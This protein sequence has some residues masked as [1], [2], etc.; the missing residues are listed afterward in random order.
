MKKYI[1]LK[2]EEYFSNSNASYSFITIF[3]RISIGLLALID[4]LSI[5][6]DI[7]SFFSKDQTIIPQE[8]LYL[9]SDYY[10]FLK[11][12]Y[13][14]LETNNYLDL[15]YNNIILLYIIAL[16]L[17]IIGFKSR[18][19]SII[20]LVLQLIIFKSFSSFNY[21]FDNF[22]TISFFYTALFPATFLYKED[23]ITY[24]L[25]LRR[26]LQAHLCIVYF[27]SGIAK[28]IDTGWWNG[29][30]IYKSISS[31]YKFSIELPPTIY[32]VLSFSILLMEIFYPLILFKRF[33]NIIL[34]SIISMHLGIAFFLNLYSFATIMIIWNITAFCKDFNFVK[35]KEA[36]LN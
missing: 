3:F 7:K 32:A 15:F 33:R 5:I 13:V 4:V 28:S 30:A 17:F 6:S 12:I 9:Y 8:L 11:P 36:V 27:T 1:M 20:V 18:L 31:I 25:F 16:I 19:V 2:I 21:G 14:F 22:L 34:I 10:G 35:P 24:S 23:N 26:F 29:N